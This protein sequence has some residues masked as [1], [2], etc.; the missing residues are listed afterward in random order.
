MATKKKASAKATRELDAASDIPNLKDRIYEPALI[1]LPEEINPDKSLLNIRDQGEDGACTGFSLGAA[2]DFLNAKHERENIKVSVRMLYEMAKRFDEWTGENYSGS[3]LRGAIRGWFNNGVCSE[4]IWEYNAN[5]DEDPKLT[6]ERAQQAMENPLGAYYRLSPVLTDYHTALAE[7]GVICVSAR[8]HKG[9]FNNLN[10]NK[11]IVKDE[12]LA[13][14]HAFA[15][16]GYN[17]DGFWIQNSWGKRW[18]DGG[19]ALWT[20]KDWAENIMDA[21]VFRLA[22]R[23]TH[24][25]D[26]RAGFSSN[27]PSSVEISLKAPRRF[28]IA[29]HFVH[30]D[31]GKFH[32]KGRYS[33]EESDVRAAAKSLA[34]SR[35][36]QHLLFYA[37]GGLNS[38]KSSAKRIKAMKDIF[39][40][41]G[42][43][44]YHF[45]YDTGLGE[46]FKDIFSKK[47]KEFEAKVGGFS[48]FSDN[49]FEKK[50]RKLGTMFWDEMKRD[51]DRAFHES[52][53]GYRTLEIFGD[54][55][56]NKNIKVHLIGHSTGAILH[57]H[58]LNALDRIPQWNK[59]IDTCSFLAPACS[60]D[61]F[62]ANLKG[63]LDGSSNATKLPGLNL[64][65]LTDEQELDDTV[66]PLYRK[67][68]LYLVS[69]AFE[70]MK[71]R[72]ILGMQKFHSSL[73]N[74]QKVKRF[75]SN[76][77]RPARTKSETH[78]GFDN[79]VTTMNDLLRKILKKEPIKRLFTE[80]DLK[81]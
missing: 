65:C 45:M 57:G 16:V 34:D 3:S 78:G 67:S 12:D 10:K 50:T 28:E 36:Y 24:V 71:G 41:N 39:L 59:K 33:S 20:Y 58:L 13:G 70:R 42:I 46:E 6:V 64:Y 23:T 68:L 7:T 17:K 48:D 53:A 1:S 69:N 80:S 5:P 76:E 21:W 60:L 73:R 19:L 44:P 35:K 27:D 55:I 30:I 47:T 14:G 4:N 22:V 29:N 62:K 2:I 32:E 49:L 77:G 40:E 81:Y 54:A 18:G 75:Y 52:N 31:D 25:F 38:P 66:T 63:R 9:W 43:Y 56:S 8:V 72:P 74:M 11:E 79:D 37:H 51:A 61:F 26:R 15:I